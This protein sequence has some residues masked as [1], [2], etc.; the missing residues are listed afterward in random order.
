[1]YDIVATLVLRDSTLNFLYSQ[2]QTKGQ[3]AQAAQAGG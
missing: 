1:M 2:T 3:H